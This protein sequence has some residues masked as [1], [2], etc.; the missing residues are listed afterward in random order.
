[1]MNRD[2]LKITTILFAVA[3]T[4]LAHG[5]PQPR[6]VLLVTQG[7]GA[8]WQ[9][10]AYLAAVPA[11]TVANNGNAAA[12]ALEPANSIPREVDDYLLR[13]KPDYVYHLGSTALSRKP[14]AGLLRQLSVTSADAAA[15]ALS[16]VFWKS[17]ERVVLCN[18]DDYGSALMASTLAARLRVPLFFSGREGVSKATVKRIQQLG[19]KELIFIGKAPKG[20]RAIE[21]SDAAAV[22]AWMKTQRFETPYFALVNVRDRSGT[23]I[24]RLSLAAPLLAS[25]RNGMVVPFDFDILWRVP[26]HGTEQKDDMPKG[27]KAPSHGVLEVPE[28]KVAFALT[29]GTTSDDGSRIRYTAGGIPVGTSGGAST[30]PYLQLDLN[31]DGAFDGPDEGPF[32]RSCWVPL[33]GKNYHLDFGNGRR[34]AA[35]D[36]SVSS[37][38]VEL[39]LGELRDLYVQ[40]GIPQYL[41]LVGF[42]DAIPQAIR[43]YRTFDLTSDLPYGN[44]DDDLFSEISVGRIIGESATFA[45]LH[46]SRIATYDALRSA[47]WSGKAGQSAWEQTFGSLFGNA[48]LDASARQTVEDLKWEV[49]PTKKKKGKRVDSFDADSPMTHVGFLSHAN[50]SWWKGLGGAYDMNS[51]TLLAPAVVES[52]GCLTTTLDYEPDFRSVV[53]RLFRN[54]AVSFAGQTRPGIA[55][56]FPQRSGF[57]NGVL[58]GSSIGEAHRET[59]NMMAHIALETEQSPWSGEYYQLQIRSLFG[60]PAFTPRS[61]PTMKTAPARV[62]VAGSRVSVHA[63]EN[64]SNQ[65]KFVPK[66]WK[67]WY[68][69]PLYVLRG[70][71]AYA[72]CAWSN[73]KGRDEEVVYVN[74]EF[75]TR[76]RVK[77]IRQIQSLPEPLGW[78]EKYTVDENF[79]GSRT[80]RWRVRLVDFDQVT[81]TIVN[82][83]ESIDFRVDFGTHDR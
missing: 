69:K 22:L 7:E 1:M 73:K 17:S 34:H 33:F 40:S 14:V 79:D 77:S 80:Y 11:S 60:D 26:F 15:I 27:Q 48:G 82:E 18:E 41:C 66:D 43:D 72:T 12:I 16:S 52:S 55:Q 78:N 9:D 71:G 30:G 51:T 4:A 13:F 70:S 83:V 24:P 59:Q 23:T 36:L 25:L 20:I 65:E 47:D 62:D 37:D 75:T 63:P 8:G 81:G 61:T 57:W 64:W 19:V 53:S 10:M 44:V 49:P 2:L 6:S 50:H 45:T 68:G 31:A 67:E 46:A 29:Y 28:G 32:D 3:C 39:I 56:Q 42:P 35:C 38:H 76:K 5:E 58:S 54:G 21:L 74:A